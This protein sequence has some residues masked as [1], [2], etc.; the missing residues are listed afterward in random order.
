M[1]LI[2]MIENDRPALHSS[3]QLKSSF[4]ALVLLLLLLA[5]LAKVRRYIIS[6][7]LKLGSASFFHIPWV[8][9]WHPVYSEPDRVGAY[10]TQR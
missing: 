9:A 10:L 1:S 4:L 6:P 3:Y 8:L 7:F 5:L 2:K